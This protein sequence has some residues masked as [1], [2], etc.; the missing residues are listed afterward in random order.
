MVLL[1]VVIYTLLGLLGPY[2]MG[3]AIDRFIGGKDI[4]GLLR[5]SLLMLAAYL[6]SNLFQAVS[7]WIMARSFTARAQTIAPRSVRAPANPVDSVSST[8]TRPVS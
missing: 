1:L 4:A 8:R 2:L 5:I 7:N 3:V 6:F